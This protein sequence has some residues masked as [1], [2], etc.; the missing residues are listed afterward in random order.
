M[1]EILVVGASGYFGS[2]LVEELLKY[3]GARIILGARNLHRLQSVW[4]KLSQSWQQRVEIQQLDLTVPDSLAS[5]LPRAKV[6]VCAAGPFQRLPHTLLQSCL[7]NNVHYIDLS[8]DRAFVSEAHRLCNDAASQQNQPAI[9]SGWSSMPALSALLAGIAS[10]GMNRIKRI[11]IQIA[12]GNRSPRSYATVASLLESVGRPFQVWQEN[13]WTT[14]TGWSEPATFKFPLP[15]GKR[16]GYL[17]DVPDHELFPAL[18][19][20]STVEF[21][22]GAEIAMFN[23]ICSLLALFARTGIVQTWAPLAAPMT[24]ALG[25]TGFLGHDWGA[26][27]VECT[28]LTEG[29]RICQRACIIATHHGQ[30]I[31]VMPATVMCMRLLKGERHVG[32]IVPLKEWLNRAELEVECQRRGYELV[33]H[34]EGRGD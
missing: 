1:D 34:S 20:A 6:A 16:V 9:C 21:R 19:N 2:L 18:F 32:G 26:L 28:G 4:K 33:V 11:R 7:K 24:K 13:K 14:A 12:P 8:D 10:T 30:Y 22:V 5:A 23:R 3:S 29:S 31:P 25:I 15:V 17:V 27:G